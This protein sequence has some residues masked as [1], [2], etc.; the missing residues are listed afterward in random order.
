MD[1][2]SAKIPLSGKLY[3]VHTFNFMFKGNN[4]NLQIDEYADGQC[5]GHGEHSADKN[6]VIE[7][8]SG[9]SLSQC[10]TGLIAKIESRAK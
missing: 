5:T 2:K 8:V 7:S 4:Y 9:S 1:W 6:F 3:K 10:L